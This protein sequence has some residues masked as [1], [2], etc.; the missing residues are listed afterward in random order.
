MNIR[1]Q[2]LSWNVD[3]TSEPRKKS[4][5]IPLRKPE[6]THAEWLRTNRTTTGLCG[7]TKLWKAVCKQKDLY[8]THESIL[9][10]SQKLPTRM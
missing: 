9:K 1:P 3:A 5:A 6:K 10:I 8:E 7:S 2:M 4:S